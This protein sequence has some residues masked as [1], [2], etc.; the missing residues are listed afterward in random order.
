MAT[1]KISALPAAVGIDGS[2]DYIPIVQSGV[3][4]K[5]NR[6]TL[7]GITGS[8][9][10][11]SDSQTLTNKIIGNTN[12]IT[13]KD[14]SF[15]LQNTSDTSK[16]AVFS[17]AGITTATTR[18]ITLPDASLTMVGTATT[19]TLTNKTLTSP[20]ITGGT[21]DNGTITVDSISGHTSASIVTVGG[22]QMNNGVVNTAN[23]VTSVSI[24]ASA[25]QPQ[26]LFTGTGTGWVL[27]SFAPSWTNL[28]VGTTGNT[29]VGY[30]V[31]TGKWVTGYFITIL[32]TGG[33]IGTGPVFTLPTNE[34]SRYTA[35]TF[36]AGD[37]F[38]FSNRT[39][40]RGVCAIA[41]SHKLSILYDNPVTSPSTAVQLAAV[42]ATHPET[43]SVG[44]DYISGY[45]A[46]EV[47]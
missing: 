37:A 6:T 9:V 24:A 23:A 16:Q 32:G 44:G 36:I 43:W 17:L 40:N 28:T 47:A 41:T 46:Y 39:N 4:N 18:T 14:G 31:Q 15:T 29:N 30:W 45:F 26:A 13:A 34:N 19:Q 42:D 27:T 3:T 1:V 11:T 5:I 7:L 8:P 35:G 33:S 21:Y 12:T 20:T 22:V 10:G 25:V 2:N 38:L